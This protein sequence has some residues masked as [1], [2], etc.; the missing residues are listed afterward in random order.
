MSARLVGEEIGDR[1]RGARS[2]G[3]TSAALPSRPTDSGT[4]LGLGRSRACAQR[5]VQILASPRRGT[6]VSIRRSMRSAVDLDGEDH[7][8]V[9]RRRERLRAAHAAQSGRHDQPA[10]QRCRRSAGAPLRRTSRRCPGGCPGCRCRS[11]TRRS[12]GRTSSS[13]CGRARRSGP[14]SPTPAPAWS[15]RSA[16][17]ARRRG[18]GRPRPACPTEPAASRRSRARAASR[19]WRRSTPSC[20]PP[21]RCRR[22][23][24]GPRAARPPRDRDCSSASGAPPRVCHDLQEISVPRGA[25]MRAVLHRCLLQGAAAGGGRGREALPTR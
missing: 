16:P 2:S 11:T 23:R 21:C 10:A 9:H 24:R 22:R 13:P 7:A 14:R 8:V 5:L 3:S 4:P 19:R 12:S 15:W 18:S 6:L 20:A 25:R 1:R 17:A